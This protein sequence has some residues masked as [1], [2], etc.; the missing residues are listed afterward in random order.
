MRRGYGVRAASR[1]GGGGLA[2]QEQ[3]GGRRE[4]SQYEQQQSEWEWQ[5]AEL[6]R[7]LMAGCYT[8]AQVGTAVR[9]QMWVGLDAA[10]SPGCALQL[11]LTVWSGGT[12]R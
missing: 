12:G 1:G 9:V 6:R 10:G 4:R 2:R 11:T 3:G 5:Q 8:P 7:E